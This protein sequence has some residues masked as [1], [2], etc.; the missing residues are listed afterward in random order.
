MGGWL[1]NDV[2]DIMWKEADLR[3]VGGSIRNLAE[4]IEKA[5]E[6]V[7]QDCRM[8]WT[9]FGSILSRLQVRPFLAEADFHGLPQVVP[10]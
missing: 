6:I 9:K 4:A 8:L 1:V 7:G 5:T 3:A 2:S 10:K